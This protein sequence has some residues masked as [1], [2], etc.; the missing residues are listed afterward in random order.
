MTV[1]GFYYYHSV[2]K[3]GG[4][5]FPIAYMWPDTGDFGDT[6]EKCC[7]TLSISARAAYSNIF[8]SGASNIFLL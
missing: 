2:G 6:V 5:N 3:R 8:A 1:V 7:L 4:G